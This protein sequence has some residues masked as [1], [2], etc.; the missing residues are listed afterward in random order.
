MPIADDSP[1]RDGKDNSGVD[2]PS[3]LPLPEMLPRIYEELRCLAA[4]VFRD[5]RRDHTLQPTA[6]VHEAYLRLATQE[7]LDWTNRAQFFAM[8]A[9][10]MRRV[11]RFP[12][13][14]ARL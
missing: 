13:R 7:K 4:N 14:V 10:M 5:E 11:S 1:Q 9:R 2:A 3:V 6:L 8:A 12:A